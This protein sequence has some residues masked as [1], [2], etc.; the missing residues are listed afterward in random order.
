[1]DEIVD[2]EA[3]AALGFLTPAEEA[4]V[5]REA[6]REMN[7][8]SALLAET[9]PSVAPAARLK[10]RLMNRVADWQM[11]K[12]LADVRPRDG[13][14]MSA[15]VPGVDRRKLF[16]DTQTGRTTMLLR[17]EPGVRFPA[18]FHHDDEQCYVLKGDIGWGEVMYREGDFVVMGKDTTH[19]EIHSVSGNLLLII[20]GH[21]EFV[22]A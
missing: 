13:G 12:P 6:L 10:G 9:V 21:N 2:S 3:L 7:E 11:L 8:A 20:S 19:P 14:W 22:H 16:S 1:M 4:A 17:M 15:G 18:H 5:P